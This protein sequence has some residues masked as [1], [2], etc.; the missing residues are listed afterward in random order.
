MDGAQTQKE[1]LMP[2]H[3]MQINDACSTQNYL[4]KFKTTKSENIIRCETL[5]FKMRSRQNTYIP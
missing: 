3:W 1:L 5:S 2:S 4:G